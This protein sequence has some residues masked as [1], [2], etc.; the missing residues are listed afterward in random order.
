MSYR[1][2]TISCCQP[3]RSLLL[4][5]SFASAVDLANAQ[6]ATPSNHPNASVLQP[7]SSIL[8]APAEL[9]SL[10]DWWNS[11]QAGYQT[12][13]RNRVNATANQTVAAVTP[14]TLA[15]AQNQAGI[16]Q[17]KAL[18]WLATGNGDIHSAD[19]IAVKDV[20]T[21]HAKVT[22][23]SSL[24]SPLVGMGYFTAFDFINSGLTSS[25]RSQITSRLD[26]NVLANLGTATRVNNHYFI[27]YG[28]RGLYALLSGNQSNLDSAVSN[29][30]DAF[31]AVTTNDGFFTD[32]D[33]YLN[34]SLGSMPGF[35]NAYKNGSGDAA[36]AAQYV[37]AAEQFARYAIGIRM[38]NG[39]SP[40]FHNSDNM[41]IAIQQL[42]RMVVDP[43]LK[44]ATV[45]YAEQL[46]PLDWGSRT[47]ALNNDWTNTDL[48]WT[49]DYS[50][51]VSEPDW[52]PT[53]HS[54]GQSKIS[55]FRNDWGTASNYFATIAGIDGDSVP[56][57]FGHHDTG[58]ITLAANGAQILVEPGYARYNGI[59]FGIGADPAMPN[60]PP[61][62][63]TGPNLDTKPAIEHNVLLAR[64]AG[65][66]AWGI[67][68]NGAA[69]ALETPDI[70]ISNRLDSSE[71]GNFKGVADFSTLQSNYTGTG[72][73]SN[74]QTRRSTGMINESESSS[75]YFVM[76]DSFRSANQ[77]NKDFAVNLIGKS[78]PDNTQIITDTAELK[79]IRWTVT[80]YFGV[81]S[82]G[83]QLSGPPYDAPTNGQVIAHI[84][85]SQPMDLV[86]ADTS[87]SI[88]NWGI[89]LQTQRMRI[90]VSN[91]DHG[92]ILTLF[93]T[94]PANFA[95]QWTVTPMSEDDFA[96][97]RID[98]SQG[99]TDWHISQTSTSDVH[100]TSAGDTVLI[101]SGELVSDAQY[102]Y[103]R[104]LDNTLDSAMISRGTTIQSRGEKVLEFDNPVTASFLF[105]NMADG[106]VL[107]TLS[108][109]DYLD[110]SILTFFDLKG[111]I[112]SLKY[113]G[114]MLGS[115]TD[116]SVT[117]PYVP[118][119][120]SVPFEIR[121]VPEPS[122]ITALAALGYILAIHSLR[123]R[124]RL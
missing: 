1:R 49:V 59:F 30:H 41:P 78:T 66:T 121:T 75:G 77:T 34:Y 70:S 44:A 9:A 8:L 14:V 117:L 68:S 120:T 104:R 56:V 33:R 35:L 48:L 5:I 124:R 32:G 113:N 16:I 46:D 27:N 21:N 4:L 54:D 122:T 3:F 80:D 96:A 98:S 115:F 92:S 31:N 10:D 116:N 88:D 81:T 74:V 114:M 18:R 45:W 107:G 2:R 51:G 71:R 28:A 50:A 95:S 36:G 84:V 20:L 61:H 85:S 110:N 12:T 63:N 94:G 118:G 53:Y 11:P 119:V 67:G 90:S 97:A 79:Q 26:A 76:A 69:Q 64:D 23:G 112:K 37:H 58:A 111:R 86:A 17:A 38:P 6:L 91:T 105:A 29:L 22:G 103:L 57:S 25:Q 89:F 99:W 43:E 15:D 123:G 39:M 73:G 52:S 24:T 100:A 83:A 101:D 13:Q 47:N 87:W 60:T 65:T 93:E 42:S 108:M 40:S 19:F 55:V 82:N 7:T 72:P 102:A 109:D 106:E 62:S